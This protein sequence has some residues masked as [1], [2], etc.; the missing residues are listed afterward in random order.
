MI[1]IKLSSLKFWL[2]MFT[3]LFWTSNSKNKV[4]MYGHGRSMRC[5]KSVDQTLSLALSKF[6][7]S[8]KDLG[9]IPDKNNDSPDVIYY[10]LRNTQSG[11]KIVFSIEPVCV[12]EILIFLFFL[13]NYSPQL[14]WFYLW[15]KSPSL[16]L[17][18]HLKVWGVQQSKKVELKCA[19]L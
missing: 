5:V 14:L 15:S 6:N 16:W 2:M 17:V 4:G 10:L 13:T 9:W 7:N 12:I 11:L 1:N 8:N 19:K 18:H 3:Y